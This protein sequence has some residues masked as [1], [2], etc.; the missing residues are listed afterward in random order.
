MRRLYEYKMEIRRLNSKSKIE[1]M[2][3]IPPNTRNYEGQSALYQNVLEGMEFQIQFASGK[4]TLLRA[5]SE[6]DLE[7]IFECLKDIS[8][9]EWLD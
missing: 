3:G 7:K 5:K 2:L 6:E 1:H 8:L 9:P 4:P